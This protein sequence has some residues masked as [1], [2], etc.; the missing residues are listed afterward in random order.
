MKPFALLA[1]ALLALALAGPV[2]AADPSPLAS[3]CTV[4]SDGAIS[5]PSTDPGAG[6]GSGSSSGS[7]GS[8][9][10]TDP[11]APAPSAGEPAP[12]LLIAPGGEVPPVPCDPNAE[13]CAMADPGVMPTCDPNATEPCPMPMVMP[14]V[15]ACDPSDASCLEKMAASSGMAGGGME[16]TGMA[17]SGI[18]GDGGATPLTVAFIALGTLLGLGLGLVAGYRIRRTS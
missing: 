3:D 4:S 14:G 6:S 13:V 7:S 11:V 9:A 10:A 8:G 1:A 2:A 12:S 16:I 17:R 15:V 5:C 18:G